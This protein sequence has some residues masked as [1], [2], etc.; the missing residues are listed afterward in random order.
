LEEERRV[1]KA[2]TDQGDAIG[3]RGMRKAE[4][5]EETRVKERVAM[6]MINLCQSV[7]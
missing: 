2:E 1:G 3:G 7:V 4:A 6:D 5:E